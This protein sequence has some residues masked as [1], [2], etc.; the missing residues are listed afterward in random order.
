MAPGLIFGLFTG[1]A[2]AA[3][4]LLEFALGFHTAR[5]DIGQYADMAQPVIPLLLLLLGIWKAA[6]P[7]PS[8]GRRVLTGALITFIGAFLATGFMVWYLKSLNPQYV[9]VV[10][11]YERDKLL[12]TG[13]PDEIVVQNVNEMRLRYG[14]GARLI[15]GFFRQLGLG[16]AATVAVSAYL[17]RDGRARRDRQRKSPVGV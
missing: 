10:I 13:M 7:T 17:S 8:F 16:A 11:A 2:A 9:D 14:A 15:W 5:Y 1:I 3:Y 6:G 4:V 12:G